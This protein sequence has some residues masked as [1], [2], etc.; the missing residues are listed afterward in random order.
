[1]DRKQHTN[2]ASRYRIDSSSLQYLIVYAVGL[3]LQLLHTLQC[4]MSVL[5]HRLT[6]FTFHFLHTLRVLEIEIE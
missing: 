5:L 3:S 6:L 2:I 4:H 1:M